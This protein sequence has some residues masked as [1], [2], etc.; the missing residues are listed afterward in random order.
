M[1]N[2]I[3]RAVS[4]ILVVGSRQQDQ[5]VDQSADLAFLK[6]LMQWMDWHLCPK[7][8]LVVKVLYRRP[9]RFMFKFDANEVKNVDRAAAASTRLLRLW[10]GFDCHPQTKALRTRC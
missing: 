10:A 1:P 7:A 8:D 9:Y 6:I 5:A 3:L 4:L 2:A